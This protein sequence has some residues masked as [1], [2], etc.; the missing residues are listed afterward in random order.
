MLRQ[1]RCTLALVAAALLGPAGAWA[2][3]ATPPPSRGALLYET[4]CIACHSTQ[5]HWRNNK[6][7]TD[8]PSLQREVRRW[9]RSASLDWSDDDIDEVARHLNERYYR[10]AP[11]G[12]VVSLKR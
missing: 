11:A 8:W 6:V 2:Q 3:V 12:A 5:M 4:H 10:F 7:A 1:I 9:Q